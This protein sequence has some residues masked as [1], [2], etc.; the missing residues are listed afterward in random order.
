MLNTASRESTSG[1]N[2]RGERG[3]GG[4]TTGMSASF[5]PSQVNILS[6]F[7]SSSLCYNSILRF[8]IWTKVKT[9]KRVK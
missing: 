4:R 8:L 3:G 1:T 6:K 5:I 2:S 7:L 9:R